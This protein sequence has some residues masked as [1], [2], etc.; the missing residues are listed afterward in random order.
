[1]PNLL[2]PSN[3]PIL[4]AQ[5]SSGRLPLHSVLASETAAG[6]AA[7]CR[8]DSGKIIDSLPAGPFFD[9]DDSFACDDLTFVPDGANEQKF[10]VVVAVQLAAEHTADDAE[11]DAD[12][13]GLH[14]FEI[15]AHS[16]IIAG[17]K[18]LDSF[19]GSIPSGVLDLVDVEVKSVSR[20]LGT[21]DV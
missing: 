21:A 10:T 2:T 1:M 18:T 20:A 6:F 17:E 12:D 8:A 5:T 4:F 14:Y 19:H 13:L 11:I 7:K 3:K 16:E 15:L 9:D